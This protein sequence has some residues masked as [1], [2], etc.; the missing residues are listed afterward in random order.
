[1]AGE[2]E[3]TELKALVAELSSALADMVVAL[4]DGRGPAEEISTT[5][6]EMLQA[7]RDRKPDVD[8]AA[9]LAALKTLRITAPEV[10]VHNE[11]NVSPTPIHNNLPAPVVQFIEREKADEFELTVKYDNFDRITNAVIK[12]LPAK[13]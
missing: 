4:Q 3:T 11:I 1:M 6:V 2:Q 13:K 5:L 7:M 9:V 10:K 12:R 8:T